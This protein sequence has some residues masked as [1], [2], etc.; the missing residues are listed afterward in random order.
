MGNAKKTDSQEDS[1]VD[2][3]AP[4]TELL[5]GQFKI[6]EFLNSGGFGITYLARDSLGRRVVIKECFPSTFCHRSRAIVQP[7]SR[8]HQKELKSVVDLFVQEARSLAKLEHPNIVGVHQVFEDN[9]TAY[10]VLDFVEGRDLL[11]ML[12]SDENTLTAPQIKGILKDVLGAV[13][14]IHDQ[15]ILHR[16]ISPDNILLDADMRPVLIDFGAAREEATK[17][18]RVLSALRV[19]KD[20][21][22]PQEF[23][24]QGSAQT[25][26]SDL[27]ALGATFYHLIEG[28]IPP[29]S[30]SRLA[31]IA[32]GEKDLYEPLAD[33]TKGF[34]KKFLNAID[35]ALQILPKDRLQSAQE[36]LDAMEGSRRKSRV[37]TTPIP[38]SS[39]AAAT[40]AAEQRQKSKLVPLLGSAAA[41]AIIAVA[42][43]VGTGTIDLS[44][45]KS[46]DVVAEAEKE[47]TEPSVVNT[48]VSDIAAAEA[49]AQRDVV[50]ASEKAADVAKA[51]R[52]AEAAAAEAMER[53]KVDVAAAKAAEEEAVRLAEIAAAEAALQI[54][55]EQAA[56]KAAEGAETARLAEVAAVEEVARRE[57][58]LAAA[59]AAD[60]EA[61]RLAE[62]AAAEQA[63]QREAE[64][65]AAKAAE[66]AEAARLAEI[67]A[68]EAAAR[69]E[70]ELAAAKAAE[71]EAARLAE[72]AA[73]EEAAQ[74]EAELAAAKA[75][76]EAEAARLAE[77]A[78]L[79]EAARR[80]AELA[81]AKAAEEEA[82]RL[83]EVAAA[84]EAARREAELAAAKA[85]EKEAQRLAEAAAAEAAA[86]RE[87][88]L[89]AAKAAEEAEAERL[90]EIAAAEEA[91]RLEKEAVEEVA[92]VEKVVEPELT[93]KE[94]AER[95]KNA[96]RTALL[97]EIAAASNAELKARL[98]GRETTQDVSVEQNDNAEPTDTVVTL[99]QSTTDV[100][101][102]WSL[103]LPFEGQ[104]GTAVI[105]EVDAVSPAWALTGTRIVSVN[106]TSINRM[107]DITDL[108]RKTVSP[109]GSATQPVVF[110]LEPADGGATF[111]QP[112]EFPIVQETAL[113]N[114]TQFTTRFDGEAWKTIVT[115]SSGTQDDFQVGDEVVALMSTSETIQGRTSLPEILERELAEGKD[116]FSFAVSR[117]GSM[118]VV[119]LTYSGGA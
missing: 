88:E 77:I 40:A 71:E 103:D 60:E 3:L 80:E 72:I 69:Q 58:E 118:W 37:M 13:A 51:A 65:A 59:K 5:H 35:M 66:E 22:S 67:A 4:G 117:A 79:E 25:P 102:D 41:I 62:I 10:M 104:Q 56:A 15:D 44:G 100:V 49:E 108:L 53:S 116:Q 105:G 28:D 110:V 39:A 6:E 33:R 119:S 90:A 61:E 70:A 87:L 29:N 73:A 92:A 30:Q 113:L 95:E 96:A 83:A 86:Q 19:V 38:M 81:A 57:A 7:R 31:A 107:S 46:A 9:E 42:G 114:G 54:E 112:W 75:A 93:A 1:Y 106:G 18:S 36:W 109:E 74:R 101:S 24:V 89:A 63:A 2:E 26:S 76:E 98:E 52:L 12:E 47:P 91:K 48:S 111:E 45:G 32:A 21:Y 23:Y 14:Y 17:K 11:D 82:K 115:A 84:E 64:L 55:A 85:A 34:D 43:L 99:D 97:F 8:A 94:R 27:Y 78:A 20:G 50:I 16:D 68:A